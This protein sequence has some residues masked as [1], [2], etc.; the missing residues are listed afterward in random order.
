MDHSQDRSVLGNR[1]RTQHFF[2]ARSHAA[3]WRTLRSC[4][5]QS[6]GVLVITGE[7]GIGKSQLLLQLQGVLPE[8]WDM[9]MTDAGQPQ[10]LFTQALCEA[11]GAEIAGPQ[12][13]AI[14]A[15]E[16]L[17]AL[18]GRMEFGRNL[19]IAVDNA[20]DLT[21]ENLNILNNILVFSVSR[22]YPV[23][24]L[25]MGRPELAQHLDLASFQLLRNATIATVEMP[26]LTRLEVREYLRYQSKRRL[27]NIPY[28]TWPAWLELFAT[29]RGNPQ[30]L[31]QLLQQIVFLNKGKEL[32]IL[33][34]ALVN[35]GRMALDPNDHPMPGRAFIPWVGLMVLLTALLALY[36]A[37]FFALSVTSRHATS[38]EPPHER[39]AQQAQQGPTLPSPPTEEGGKESNPGVPSPPPLPVLP[40]LPVTATTATPPPPPPTQATATEGEPL[41]VH[42]LPTPDSKPLKRTP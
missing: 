17:D 14:T 16:L 3:V 6:D 36:G 11:V 31:D 26:A 41:P 15:D 38:P 37:L 13:W 10:T 25:L 29:S 9:A 1:P 2:S 24:I 28:I 40:P 4:L 32:R 23:Q 8:S 35:K 5:T 27:G 39:P 34:S 21:Q 22:A 7:A 30:Q 18:S 33:T 12:E 20:Q 19:L 42:P